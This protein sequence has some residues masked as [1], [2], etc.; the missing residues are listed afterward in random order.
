MDIGVAVYYAIQMALLDFP[1]P[2]TNVNLTCYD[3]KCGDVPAYNVVTR[4]AAENATAIIGEICSGASLAAQG[5]VTSKQIPMIS[6][7]SSASALSQVD[8]F[9]R[10]VPS[11]RYQGAAL[12]Q[13]MYD[14]G[15]RA[16]ALVYSDNTYGYGLAFNFIA[17]YTKRGGSVPV[18]IV[19]NS[20]EIVADAAVAKIKQAAAAKKVDSILL[21]MNRVSWATGFLSNAAKEKLDLPVFAGDGLADATLFTALQGSTS[22]LQR[23]VLT[24]FNPGLEQFQARFANFTNN[25]LYHAAAAHAFDATEALVRAYKAAAAPKD[26]TEILRQLQKERFDGVSGFVEFDQY[27]DRIPSDTSYVTNRFDMKTGKLL[28]GDP[29]ELYLSAG[30]S[31]GQG[32]Q[33]GTATPAAGAA[34]STTGTA[35]QAA[36]NAT[37][38]AGFAGPAKPATETAK[39]TTGP[40]K[41]SAGGVKPA[42]QAPTPKPDSQPPPAGTQPPVASIK[43]PTAGSKASAAGGLPAAANLPS[44]ITG[45]AE[46]RPIGLVDARFRP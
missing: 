26:G 31:T 35:A 38:V 16:V 45:A 27:G 4:L 42:A 7:A 1:I 11:D 30:N 18:V 44:S 32:G 19:L 41:P 33:G 21:A 15:F 2:G 22:I 14:D 13:Q 23:M 28:Y 5:I 9:F 37:S 39:A 36:G 3:S 40:G 8:F 17:S 10:T 34:A 29:I 20:S 43:A 12:A 6:P 24:G 25:T 46:P